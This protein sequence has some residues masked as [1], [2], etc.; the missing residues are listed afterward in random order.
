MSAYVDRSDEMRELFA[1]ENNDVLAGMFSGAWLDTQTFP[2]LEFSVPGIIPEGFGLLVAP[3]KAGK[4]WLVCDIGL[5][6]AAGGFAL[7]RVSVD[8]R[9]VLYLALE[10][11]Q[12]R[13]QSRSRHIMG[14]QPIP[15]D[16]HFVTKAKPA[17][18]IPMIREF[19]HRYGRDKPLVIVDTLGKARPPR[20]PGADLYAWDYAI[21]SQLKEVIDSSP[22]A[23]LVCVHHSRKA[24]SPD[25]VDSVSGSAGIAGSADFVLVLARKRHSDEALL[26]VTGRDIPEVEY[27]L[28]TDN[29]LWCLD[30]ASL[31]D[32]ATTA[33]QRRE[34]KD[35][36]DR[37]LEVVAFVNQ[38][39]STGTRAADLTEI[40]I[41][42]AQARVY[43]SRLA[44][45][46]HIKKL[47]RGLYSGVTSVTSV[48]DTE[49]DITE[50]TDVTPFSDNVIPF[51]TSDS[52]VGDQS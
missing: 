25:F 16:I 11:G 27:A 22:G 43:L 3:P 44:G 23:S 35:L 32:A 47:G 17:C 46:G 50:I 1:E 38:N 37:S 51:D 10:D 41:D 6:C 12:R 39:Q 30:G 40:G 13:L 48:T 34:K 20:P 2:P 19:L 29:G 8:K 24:E 42:Q 14:G 28:T 26:S 4:S 18:V 45:S 36:G 7:S 49:T 15:A 21:G 33:E 52:T 9:Q 31:T 5:A